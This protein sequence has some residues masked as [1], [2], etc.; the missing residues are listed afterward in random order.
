MRTPLLLYGLAIAV[1]L[2]LV[3]LFPDPAYP[4][5]YYYVEVARSLAAGHGF[6]VPFIWVFAEVG[7]RIP[8]TPVLPIPSNAHWL[9]LASLIQVPSIL[10]FGSSP[11]AAALPRVLVSAT[12]APLIWAIARDAGTKPI[13]A[14]GAGVLAAIP[15]AGAVFLGQPEN[16]GLLLPLVTATLWLVARGLKGSADRSRSPACSPASPRSRATTASSCSSRSAS[17][18]SAT[19][20]GGGSRADG[21]APCDPATARAGANRR[22]TSGPP[23]PLPRS[24]A[25]G[26][27]PLAAA[28]ACVALFLLVIGPWW[29]R[30]VA[31][32]GS[33][34]PTGV[35]GAALWFRDV[36]QWNSI[37][38]D[39]SLSGFLAQ[40]I[41]PIVASRV[42]GLIAAV[43][44]FTVVMCSVVL[45]PLLVV[46]A[47]RRRRSIDFAPWFVYTAV[48]FAAAALV[49][50][51]LVPSGSFIHSSIGLAPYAYILAL[52]GVLAAVGWVA[53]RRR[54]WDAEAAGRIFVWATVAFAVLAAIPFGMRAM[55]GWDAVRQPRIA[56]AAE[57]DRL[58]VPAADR[59]LSIDAAG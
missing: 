24:R 25:R 29:I 5:S 41:G 14:T 40:G 57:L 19:G 47:W 54:S 39:A 43:A 21:R 48:V 28:V 37:T 59:L 17:C 27:V 15:A 13:V 22:P 3:V 8:E 11:V 58:G 33:I 1:R 52:E 38:S 2:G 18:G 56:L 10:L 51:V 55:S 12:A 46:G 34:S 44:I 36:D 49:Y 4:D 30:Q 32:F 26:R 9:P 50:P 35:T 23:I 45:L 42:G 20:P 31:V 16:Y 7:N 6:T 53:Q